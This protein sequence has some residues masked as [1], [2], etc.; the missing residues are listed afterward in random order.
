MVAKL[1]GSE[2]VPD[3]KKPGQRKSLLV[4]LAGPSIIAFLGTL[5]RFAG[6]LVK[7]VET[8]FRSH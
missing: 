5:F 3:E 2:Q 4:Q 8:L 7:F 6:E 1:S